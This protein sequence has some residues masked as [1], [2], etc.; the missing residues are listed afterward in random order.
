MKRLSLA[1]LHSD[2]F[3]IVVADSSWSL[4]S[5]VHECSRP[6]MLSGN[7]MR[8]GV[9]LGEAH[10]TLS[11]DKFDIDQLIRHAKIALKSS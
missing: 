11:E 8:L 10:C 2:V 9:S 5:L 1:R 3:A 6:F 7:S 4:K